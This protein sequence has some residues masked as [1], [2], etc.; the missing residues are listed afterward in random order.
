ML[1][2]EQIEPDLCILR[3]SEAAIK[4]EGLYSIGA[5]N[6]AGSVSAS[7]FVHIAEN[8]RDLIVG[9][10]KGP[11]LVRNKKLQD[12]YDLGD[13]LGRGTQGVVYHVV[14]RNTG[15]F[16]SNLMFDG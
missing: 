15:N 4:D 3:I 2:I 1:Q 8:D 9:A 5:R 6:I 13:E 12:V 14:E 16:I 11:V 7:A 10:K